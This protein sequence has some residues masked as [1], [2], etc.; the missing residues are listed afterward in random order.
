MEFKSV[1]PILRIFSVEKA[2]EFYVDF[3]GFTL[4]WSHTFEDNFPVYMQVSRG[5]A[6]LHLTEHYGEGVPGAALMID[7]AGIEA[8]HAE[9]TAKNYKFAKPGLEPMPWGAR[10][11]KVTDPFGNRLTFSEEDKKA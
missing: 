9:L 2:K 10:I 3:L 4:D 6:V 7:M 8:F 11:V 1:V 5:A